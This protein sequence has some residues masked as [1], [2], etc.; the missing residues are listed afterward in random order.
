MGEML[1]KEKEIVVPGENLASGMDYLPGTGTYRDNDKIVALRLG[2]CNISGRAIKIIPLSGQYV[3]KRDDTVIGQVID[4]TINGWRI[5]INC[6]YS[7]M[8]SMKDATSEYIARGADL[9]KYYDIGDW[10]VTGITNVTS[11]KLVDLTMKGLGLRKLIGGR[12]IKVN[13]NKVPRIIG[14]QGSMVTMIKQYTT[15]RITVGQNGVIWLEGD[16]PKKEILAVDTIKTIERESHIPGLTEKI[17]KDLKK[18]G[19]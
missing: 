13:T 18:K 6:A 7:A 19:D 12:I 15:T 11:Q 9:T 17:E 5:D 14:K 16:D 4:V 3:P 1:V 2:L 10:V 8:L